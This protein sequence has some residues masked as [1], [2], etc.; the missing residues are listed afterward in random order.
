MDKRPRIFDFFVLL[1]AVVV[2]SCP[3]YILYSGVPFSNFDLYF[4]TTLGIAGLLAGVSIFGVWKPRP[5]G[6]L[7]LALSV[8][9]IVGLDTFS[10]FKSQKITLYY[11]TDLLLVASGCF[12]LAEPKARKLFFDASLRWWERAKRYAL[13]KPTVVESGDRQRHSIVISDIS[14][15][16][17]FVTAQD[18]YDIGEV[19][20]LVLDENL[21]LDTLVV[22]SSTNG[23]GLQFQFRSFKESRKLKKFI[24]LNSKNDLQNSS[25]GP[26]GISAKA[27]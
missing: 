14:L 5:W 26:P 10:I 3:G 7:A 12:I 13:G 8:A 4:I 11:L 9:L 2:V 15:T 25:G 20:K 22:R 6:Y 27:A 19:L 16:G 24:Q 21:S 17:C 1:F 18:R 23:V